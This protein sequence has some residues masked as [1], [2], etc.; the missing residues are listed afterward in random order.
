MRRSAA[1]PEPS[2]QRRRLWAR[3]CV[4]LMIL[5]CGGEPPP[6]TNS[7]PIRLVEIVGEANVLESPLLDGAD[8]AEPARRPVLAE[9]FDDF[10]E[11]GWQWPAGAKA[12]IGSHGEL[13]M[14]VADESGRPYKLMIPVEGSRVYRIRRAIETWVPDVDLVVSESTVSPRHPE[15]LNH[16]TDYK[17]S[18]NRSLRW[19]LVQTHLFPDPEIGRWQTDEIEILTT[20]QTR[21]LEL[22]FT[23]T[24]RPVDVWI[25]DLSID[26]LELPDEQRARWLR[27][28]HVLPGSDASLGIAKH[29][30][31]LPVVT[32]RDELDSPGAGNY[33]FRSALYAPTPTRLRF[34]LDV[35]HGAA[36][37]FATGLARS[38]RAGDE[39]TWRVVV[40]VDGRRETLFSSRLHAA[41]GFD[42]HQWHEREVSLAGFGGRR[43]GLELIT[44]APPGRQ[45][46]AVWGTPII[47][48]PRAPDSPPNVVVIAVDTL[49]ADRL[50]VYGHR[51]ELSRHLSALASDG[52]KLER[53]Y[54][55]SNWTTPS[56]TTLFTGLMPSRHRVTGFGLALSPAHRTLA[57]V[58]STHGWITHAALYKPFLYDMGLER[59]FDRWFNQPFGQARGER[60]TEMVL[61]WLTRNGHRRFFLFWHMN[62]PHQPFNVPDAYLEEAGATPL[63]K[64]FG[65]EMPGS[66]DPGYR[67]RRCVGERASREGCR[68]CRRRRLLPEYKQMARAIYD[69]TV[70]Y[71]D[72]QVGRVVEALK[73]RDLYDDTLIVFVADHGEV[74]WDRSEIFGHGGALMHQELVRIPLI[75]KPHV[76]SGIP[77]GWVFEEPVQLMDVGAT[78]LDLAGAAQA[79]GGLEGTSFASR[80]D[81]LS[82]ASPSIAVIENVRE[83]VLAVKGRRW[84]LHLGLRAREPV[85]ERLFDLATDPH[86][87]ENV[88]EAHP[89]VA[90]RLRAIAFTHLLRNRA[91][92]YLVLK[93]EP[94]PRA[95]RSGSSGGRTARAP[96]GPRPIG[97]S[98]FEGDG[99]GPLALFARLPARI[100]AGASARRAPRRDGATDSSARAE[101][102]PGRRRLARATPGRRAPR[103][104]RRSRGRRRE[105]LAQ[106]RAAKRT[107]SA[108]LRRVACAAP[109]PA[110]APASVDLLVRPVEAHDGRGFA[111][112]PV[113]SPTRPS[114]TYPH[115]YTRWIVR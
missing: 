86:E 73:R 27:D 69:A 4:G 115:A 51:P 33:A 83:R 37:T 47:V 87:R 111:L 62:D 18:M 54:S 95:R 109:A 92:L 77:T 71:V 43:I 22:N 76:A 23:A 35:P 28:R 100:P 53:A 20:P 39:A 99:C 89:D 101:C 65:F 105:A 88:I 16:P 74:L 104:R 61:D 85:V 112:H 90:A 94:G 13:A 52:V 57:E 108:G 97:A 72:D 6:I 9:G 2:S 11:H 8:G 48:A 46:L 114:G 34:E 96:L 93:S 79:P 21:S 7:E 45:G 15:V 31:I 63:A 56:F 24:K 102:G 106:R 84:S 3:A 91:G 25:D 66:I 36:F 32:P 30:Q 5:G 81:P 29:G 70:H 1:A 78:L 68:L 59:G 17:R 12:G 44:E 42:G 50:G 19:E 26:E 58:F 41:D 49:R 110:P 60:S 67:C 55:S 40:E 80:L 14:H 107:R 10:P 98:R 103:A 64:Q 113:Q 75:V 38:T 82:K